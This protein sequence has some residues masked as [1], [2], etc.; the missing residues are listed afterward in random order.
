MIKIVFSIIKHRNM[1]IQKIAL[2][3]FFLLLFTISSIAQ[4]NMG[5]H[6]RS[7][8]N[9]NVFEKDIPFQFIN[10]EIIITVI[11]KGKTYHF[12]FDTGA[13]T[14]ISKDIADDLSLEEVGEVNL[15]DGKTDFRKQ[16]VYNIDEIKL[17]VVGFKNSQCI[18]MNTSDLSKQLCMHIDGIIGA[19]FMRN[20]FWKI[21]F[22]NN[23]ITMYNSTPDI[24][25]SAIALDFHEGPNGSPYIN[26]QCGDSLQDIEFDTGSNGPVTISDSLWLNSPQGKNINYAVLFGELEQTVYK[27]IRSTEYLCLA[28]ILQLNGIDFKNIILKCRDMK[29]RIQTIGTVF[30]KNYQVYL[31][32]ERHKIFLLQQNNT[33]DDRLLRSTGLSFGV[34]NGQLKITNLWKNSKA[35]KEGIAIG[36]EITAINGEHFS[37]LSEDQFCSLKE[38]IKNIQVLKLTVKGV[39]N[40]E[41]DYELDRYDLLANDN[42]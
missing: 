1:S 13:S 23:T 24:P 40:K 27:K 26:M 3:I 30:M 25:Q 20:C 14:I 41:R 17:G 18:S 34:D 31:D 10:G 36:D 29:G 6:H 21:D 11:I 12:I 5:S 4:H 32:W 7:G 42:R 22:Q 8:I 39:D 28:P 9:R 19:N 33:I 15:S 37:S 16:K 38:R 2:T 35:E